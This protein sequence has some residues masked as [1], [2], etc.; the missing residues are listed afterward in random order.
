MKIQTTQYRIRPERTDNRP[1]SDVTVA[2]LS[3]LHNESFGTGGI[4][5][6]R[7]LEQYPLQAILCAGD[8]ATAKAGRCGFDQ[9]VALA[10]NLGARW[11]VYAVNGNHEMR[12][13]CLPD[14][15]GSLYEIY[16]GQLSD[17][18][19]VLL[20]NASR[21]LTFSG[22]KISLTGFSQPLSWYAGRPGKKD[23]L[24]EIRAAVGEPDPDAYRILL[25]HHPNYFKDFA[26]WGAD[27]TIAGHIHGGTVR[28]PWIGGLIGTDMVPFPRYD[29]GLYMQYG[30][31]MIVSAG[32]GSHTVK[33]RINNPPEVVLLT[34]QA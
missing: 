15:Y 11:P 6:V 17:A 9:A 16:T 2:I 12:M 27:L 26:A 32:L 22:M 34:F 10:A 31:R 8:L 18:G 33:L 14:Q 4:S 21:S 20:D 30:K 25:T 5:L 1:A 29:K 28:L 23:T 24:P 19:V 13:K 7:V 3:D